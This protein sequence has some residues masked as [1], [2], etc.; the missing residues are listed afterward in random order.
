[1]NTV[2]LREELEIYALDFAYQA[3]LYEHDIV[4]ENEK[5]RR[6]HTQL[7][8]LEDKNDLLHVQIARDDEHI[9]R[10][11]GS[12]KTSG[13]KIKRLEASLESTQGV[14]RV[15]SREI[16]T[17]KTELDSLHGVTMDSTKLL[18]EKLSLQRE[19][20]NLRPQLDHLQSQESSNRSL[21]ADKLALEHQMMALRLELENEKRS[22]Q[23]ILAKD[24][25]AR[26]EDAKL[27]HQLKALQAE[28]NGE[29]REKAKVERES[30]EASN[31][32]EAQ[33]LTLESRLESFRS[34]LR[35]TK[36]SLKESQQEL[37]NS[38]TEMSNNLQERNDVRVGRDATTNARKRTA[39][40][41]QSDS[42]IGTPGNMA[43]DRRTKRKSTL[44]GDKS[45]FSITPY[46]N[47]RASVAPQSPSEVAGETVES[48]STGPA[49]S[50]VQDVGNTAKKTVPAV[51]V[52][53]SQNTMLAQGK[54]GKGS[55]KATAERT[56]RNSART[57]EQVAEEDKDDENGVED[58]LKHAKTGANNEDRV[59]GSDILR[60]KRRLLGGSFGKTLFDE[61]DHES[62]KAGSGSRP[63]GSLSR[64]A[65]GG[66]KSRQLLMG[67]AL[68][69]STISAF[70]PLK[71]HG[72]SARI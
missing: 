26:A 23:R 72:Q 27:D 6:I 30:Q 12:Q 58:S 68:S 3:R 25:T 40:Q 22:I 38:R 61:E 11:E 1:M 67:Q 4:Q 34:K 64:G 50:T 9:Y 41:M 17:L 33:K 20:N 62:G 44:P 49:P 71:R 16:E 21:L 19:L 15:K 56:K 69:S 32:W 66:S 43:E 29:R 59:A 54:N 45:T 51:L 63:F 48:P 52:E 55:A 5:Y 35:S 46:L 14:L 10:L 70:S 42:M 53:I 39:K 24:V 13:G 28:L 31:A 60:K 8:L 2:E 47:R 37:Q 7:L 18:T 57:L 65:F 36:E